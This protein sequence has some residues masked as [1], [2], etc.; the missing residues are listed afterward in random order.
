MQ[1]NTSIL[2]QDSII[3]FSEPNNGKVYHNIFVSDAYGNYLYSKINLKQFTVR[4]DGWQLWLTNINGKTQKNFYIC[5]GLT[6]GNLYLGFLFDTVAKFN[7][8]QP[9]H[10]YL[11][12]QVLK[13]L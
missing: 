4:P 5:F 9:F 6:A 11:P 1:I 10:E 8:K 7:A 13:G 3:R 2:N 12:S